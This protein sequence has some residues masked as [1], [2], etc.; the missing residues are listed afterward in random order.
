MLLDFSKLLGNLVVKYVPIYTK[1]TLKRISA[2]V[3]SNDVY[4]Y[5]CDLFSDFLCKSTCYGYSFESH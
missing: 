5:F 1:G 3:L 2:K 4:A